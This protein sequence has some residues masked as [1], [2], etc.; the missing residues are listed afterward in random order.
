MFAVRSCITPRSARSSSPRDGAGAPRISASAARRIS[1]HDGDPGGLPVVSTLP[2]AESTVQTADGTIAPAT[3]PAGVSWLPGATCTT[4]T[5]GLTP[6][7]IA[8]GRQLASAQ[9]APAI[10]AACGF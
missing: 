10:A 3:G 8:L 6:R 5:P 7:W 4:T 1:E 2:V 9:A